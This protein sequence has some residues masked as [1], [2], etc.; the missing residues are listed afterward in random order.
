MQS[1]KLKIASSFHSKR[2]WE[3]TIFKQKNEKECAKEWQRM[4]KK[5]I[6]EMRLYSCVCNERGCSSTARTYSFTLHVYKMIREIVFNRGSVTLK[7]K[8]ER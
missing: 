3:I 5:I 6:Q 1:H 4:K 2:E 7:G 8:R